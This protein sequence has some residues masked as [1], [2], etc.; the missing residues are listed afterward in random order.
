MLCLSC[1]AQQSNVMSIEPNCEARTLEHGTSLGATNGYDKTCCITIFAAAQENGPRPGWEITGSANSAHSDGT[2]WQQKD[3]KRRPSNHDCTVSTFHCFVCSDKK[4]EPEVAKGRN[5]ELQLGRCTVV[6][7][8]RI[9]RSTANTKHLCVTLSYL[10]QFSRKYYEK[11]QKTTIWYPLIFK[12]ASKT[13]RKRQIHVA[14]SPK[15]P[16]KRQNTTI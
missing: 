11:Q 3:H 15:I 16:Q 5:N 8:C 10:A 6:W 4:P 14:N 7:C 9:A 1:V 12:N 2:S 13:R